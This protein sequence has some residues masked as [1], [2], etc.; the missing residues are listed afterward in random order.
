MIDHAI[1]ALGG[2]CEQC[3]Q[4]LETAR[5]HPGAQGRCA[6]LALGT[7]RSG[8]KNQPSTGSE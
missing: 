8:W 1:G 6:L 2:A 4:A 7:A 5:A 3:F